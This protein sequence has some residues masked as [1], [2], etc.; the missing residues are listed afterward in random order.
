MN[1]DRNQPRPAESRNDPS[2]EVAGRSLGLEVLGSLGRFI[3]GQLIIAAIMTVLYALGFLLIGMPFWWLVAL[4]CGP[5]H[6]IPFLGSVIAV[7]IPV[8]FILIAGGDLWSVIYVL[9]VFVAV[10]LV[11]TLYLTPK[12]LGRELSLHPLLVLAAV[13]IGAL[14]AGPI[15]ALLAS[16]LVAV[17]MVI[18]KRVRGRHEG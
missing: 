1:N 16:P 12:I 4:I 9:L 6:L 3:R 17:V 8:G 10:Q 13:L 14:V 5:L 7:V 2:N 11:E 18:W 15:G